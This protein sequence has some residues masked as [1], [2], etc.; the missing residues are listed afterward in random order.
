MQYELRFSNS[1]NQL[2]PLDK[3]SCLEFNFKGIGDILVKFIESV[4]YDESTS[5]GSRVDKRICFAAGTPVRALA[6][7]FESLWR[8]NPRCKIWALSFFSANQVPLLGK[9]TGLLN[10]TIL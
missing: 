5:S 9:R 2:L 1:D 10:V 7:W 4:Y 3:T 6:C 8:H